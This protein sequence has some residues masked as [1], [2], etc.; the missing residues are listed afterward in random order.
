MK[1]IKLLY[2]LLITVLTTASIVS[3]STSKEINGV[4]I[5]L[6]NTQQ[7]D[8]YV[9][10]VRGEGEPQRIKIDGKGEFKFKRPKKG[11]HR[12]LTIK[13][14][15]NH[16]VVS[17][18]T[19]IPYK[20]KSVIILNN[21]VQFWQKVI[22]V[23]KGED[24]NKIYDTTVNNFKLLDKEKTKEITGKFVNLGD[25]SKEISFRIFG[26]TT[27]DKFINEEGE[28]R[29]KYPKNPETEYK[30]II[31]HCC[32]FGNSS[33]IFIEYIPIDAERIIALFDSV[34]KEMIFV[35][36][37]EDYDVIYK[38][39]LQNFTQNVSVKDNHTVIFP[40]CEKS[41]DFA[42][43][44]NDKINKHFSKYLDIRD[45]SSSS[46]GLDP[47]RHRINIQFEV[48]EKGIAN[49]ILVKAPHKELENRVIRMFN[50]L[51][52]MKAA[53]KDNKPIKTEYNHSITVV[54]SE[55]N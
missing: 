13:N 33:T 6:D 48:D 26:I 39:A 42:S 41:N 51:P 27:Q 17:N 10:D 38:N 31:E 4:F 53:I 36:K 11:K 55:N 15:Y 40:G 49:I 45:L 25:K 50:K 35:K 28:F 43:C 8:G 47:G 52:V 3:C 21:G 37:G 34:N 14:N 54:L 23:N 44:F 18:Y 16:P 22:L 1:R 7:N 12:E 9:A 32:G 24:F 19:N 2:G 5:N 46:L 30:I 29:F 20:A